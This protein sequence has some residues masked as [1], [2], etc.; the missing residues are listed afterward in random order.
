MIGN[1]INQILNRT[2]IMIRLARR[3][4]K[5]LREKRTEL[6]IAVVCAADFSIMRLLEP[7]P[8]KVIFDNVIW[9]KPF[10]VPFIEESVTDTFTPKW[11]LL[12]ACIAI[13]IIA[14]LKS[15]FYYYQAVLMSQA[16]QELVFRLRRQLYTHIQRLSMAFHDRR[17]TG[18]LMMRLTGDILMLRELLVASSLIAISESLATM[19]MIVIMLWLDWRLSLVAFSVIPIILVLLNYFSKK[20]REA[21]QK[22]RK[23]EGQVAAM[24]HESISSIRIV[25]AFTRE[26]YEEDRFREQNKKSMVAGIKSSILEAKFGGF[27]EVSLAVGLCFVMLTGTGKVPVELTPGILIVFISYVRGFYRPLRR[28]SSITERSVKATACGE[29]VMEVLDMEP[30]VKD[31]PDAITANRFRGEVQFDKVSFNYNPDNPVLS[32]INFTVQPGQKIALV[33]PTG[34][35]KTTLI[36][37]ISRFYDP[38]EGCI[39]IDGKDIRKYTLNSLREQISL[40]TQESVLFRTTIKENIAYGKPDATLEEIVETAK[41]ANAH[42]FIMRFPNGYDTVIG[43]RGGTLSGGQRQCVA[44][45]RA[46]LR[47]APILIVDEPT[48][49][50]DTKS[51]NMVLESLNRLMAGRTCFAI[52]HRFST[53]RNSDR[54][55]VL[56][57]GRIIDNGTHDELMNRG[58]KYCEF[59]ELQI[60]EH[61]RNLV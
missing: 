7:W 6:I 17:E 12:G 13:I 16:G 28:I 3:F 10:T 11:I 36:S 1:R 51:E 60:G 21:A 24:M 41:Q 30:T 57:F 43:E 39:L 44:I 2:G 55:F 32:D 47:N 19:G 50:L 29:R 53:I 8:F 23:R 61:T 5:H 35:G 40:V 4:R 52:A 31:S 56:E 37:L 20:I 27:L 14:V 59:F 34:S 22:Q 26:K 54:I 49:G 33:G 9:G 46:L 42:D 45:A 15:I 25:Q 48:T 58:G 18:D 38:V